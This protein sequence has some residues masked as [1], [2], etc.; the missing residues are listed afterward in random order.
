MWLGSANRSIQVSDM[1]LEV[2]VK[3]LVENSLAVSSLHR[4]RKEVGRSG[5]M[6]DFSTPDDVK[7]VSS[8]RLMPTLLTRNRFHFASFFKNT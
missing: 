3:V 8:Q 5:A 6:E 1:D 2:P 7:L 4:L